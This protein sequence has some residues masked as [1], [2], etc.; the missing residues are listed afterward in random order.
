M[1]LALFAFGDTE[2]VTNVRR[3]QRENS[4]L[5][6]I[7]YDLN[8]TDGG[9][10]TV[11]VEIE[12]KTLAV[13]ASTFTGDV[14]EGV[15]PGTNRHIIWDAGTDWPNKKGDVRASVTATKEGPSIKPGK[16]QLWEGGPYWADRNIGAHN[17]WDYGLY[18]W[19]GDT[20]GYGPSSDGVFAF[21]FYYKNSDISTYNTY[22]SVSELESAGWVTSDRVLAR[23]HDA[24]HVK[25][26]G[27]WRMPTSQEVW[28]LCYVKC[29]WTWATTNGV[30][31]YVVRGRGAYASN[32]IFLPCAGYG[33]GTS[34]NGAGSSGR[35]W[36][37][38]PTWGDSFTYLAANDLTFGSNYY[39]TSYDNR[40][41]G[42]SVRPVQ[43]FNSIVESTVGSSDW[44]FV[45]TTEKYQD[46][47]LKFDAN[48]GTGTLEDIPL[49][50]GE[51][52]SLPDPQNKITRDGYA[53]VGWSTSLNV[54]IAN[55]LDIG[56]MEFDY[57]AMGVYRPGD[58]WCLGEDSILPESVTLYA[59]W[60]KNYTVTL[61][62]NAPM[63][64]SSDSQTVSL[65]LGDTLPRV[66]DT[67]MLIGTRECVFI[68]WTTLND[69]N[70]NV[71][72]YQDRA[73]WD[74]AGLVPGE[75]ITLYGVW[76]RPLSYCFYNNDQ[77]K[78]L[79]PK[80]LEKHVK[81]RCKCWNS[82][83]HDDGVD[84]W[85][86]GTET[87]R[88][89]PGDHEI[90]FFVDNEGCLWFDDLSPL[91]HGDTVSIPIINWGV[92]DNE[93]NITK[94]KNLSSST[95]VMVK[96]DYKT[97]GS[98][99]MPFDPSRAKIKLKVSPSSTLGDWF[100]ESAEVVAKTTIPL[101]LDRWY[102]VEFVYDGNEWRGKSIDF[103]PQD[104]APTY[105]VVTGNYFLN[106]SEGG[107]ERY[108]IQLY[109]ATSGWDWETI[110][111]EIG[112]RIYLPELLGK[113][114]RKFLG[115]YP[116]PTSWN[117]VGNGANV[118]KR[119][120]D[121]IRHKS[122][123]LGGEVEYSYRLYARWEQNI[124]EEIGG[125]LKSVMF[126]AISIILPSTVVGIQA[127]A[128]EGCEDLEELIFEGNAPEV[129]DGAL[130]ILP[131]NCVF[132]VKPTSSGWGKIPGVWHGHRIEY[133]EDEGVPIFTIEN[134]TI[135]AVDLNG[136]TN[137]I[138]PNSVTNIG[139]WAFYDCNG[140]VSVIIG[141]G[142]THIG[143]KAFG[144]CNDLTTVSFLGD[145][146]AC[147]S[148]IYENSSS[149]TNYVMTTWTGASVTW[150]GRP[151]KTVNDA[152]TTVAGKLITIPAS[153]IIRHS[154][155]LNN[156]MSGNAIAIFDSIAANGC[157]TVGECYALGIDPE[158][159]N[160]DLRITAFRKEDGQP[161]ITV[162]HTTDGSGNSFANRIR[163]LGKKTLMDAE[164]VDVT[165]ITNRSEYRFFKVS[166]EVP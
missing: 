15:P 87:I 149:V 132:Y 113:N 143:E 128:F 43:G 65:G 120:L 70:G 71:H 150:Q 148:S 100:D 160:D 69:V 122:T 41:Y 32:S 66:E 147:A 109:Y 142:I 27:G 31:G 154:Y 159:P 90:E 140:L 47:V 53:F 92:S 141:S 60:A 96:F 22:K 5:V 36:S 19:W 152:M 155:L 37:S 137:V 151:V 23:S 55:Y 18:F 117:V 39:A 25:W 145:E 118:T 144:D 44:F 106:A 111:V 30:N 3:V 73:S 138:V 105:R 114:Q 63:L 21:N 7:Y 34:L 35:Y 78:Q 68:G 84:E 83:W 116:T 45:D 77:T 86:N 13:N 94:W 81:W 28:D 166:V 64:D 50:Y 162:N 72:Y 12:G 153:W 124:G 133:F 93:W 14:G 2:T 110:S 161:V 121:R 20:K 74:G 146:P 108:R 9:T 59:I 42:Q 75:T 123:G 54:N 89:P 95:D 51:Q 17:P 158:D 163:I 26:G 139:D 62:R 103:R 134:G 129:A 57:D 1:S 16:V 136:A 102:H 67:S 52:I 61:C 46:Y 82:H 80:G 88:L 76:S 11:G 131:E 119:M 10:Y 127:S 101:R 8:A 6:D 112:D 49:S 98:G 58:T 107:G 157:R 135:T 48:L 165:D 33:Y 126:G 29:D 156:V 85:H 164:W 97:N 38:V 4:K 99:Y 40:Y 104:L 24:A 115:W 130:D 125:W 79:E 56:K 91:Q